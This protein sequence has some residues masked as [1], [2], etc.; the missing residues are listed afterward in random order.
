MQIGIVNLSCFLNL[1]LFLE[2]CWVLSHNFPCKSQMSYRDIFEDGKGKK[3]ILRK[4]KKEDIGRKKT[5]LRSDRLWG[6]F[7]NF[8]FLLTM[9]CSITIDCNCGNYHPSF[10]QFL[11]QHLYMILL[12]VTFFVLQWLLKSAHY[13]S[14]TCF[15]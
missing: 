6:L 12:L 10:L 7:W 4:S 2:E 5:I 3:H 8:L 9:V 1:I 11:Y 13:N 15:L 14:F